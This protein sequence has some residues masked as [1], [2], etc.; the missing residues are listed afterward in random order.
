MTKLKKLYISLCQNY[1]SDLALAD[2]LW[3]EIENNYSSP[4][5]HYHSLT[6]LNHLLGE[7]STVR[8]DLNNWDCILFTLF[9]HDVIY[10]PLQKNNEAASAEFA[11]KDLQLLSVPEALINRCIS[12]IL[13]TKSHEPSTDMDT[14]YFLD[15]DL[16]ILGAGCEAYIQYTKQIRQEYTIYPD[17]LYKPGRKK[18]LQHFLDMDR[19]FKTPQFYDRLEI[20]ARDNMKAEIV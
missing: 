16:S 11:K 7:L 10:N 6:H 15:A 8:A 19:I 14:N 2:D 13:A 17:F 9:Y 4:A 12:Q 1:S 5:R 20:N 18:V 3:K